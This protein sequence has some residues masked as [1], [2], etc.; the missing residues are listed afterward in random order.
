MSLL[1]NSDNTVRVTLKRLHVDA[2]GAQEPECLSFWNHYLTKFEFKDEHW[3]V[4]AEFRP[5]QGSRSRIDRGIR[6]LA[7]GDEIIVLCWIEAKGSDSNAKKKEAEQQAL[8]ACQV[9]LKSHRWQSFIYALTTAKTTA[10]AWTY[11]R[12][13]TEM[14]PLWDGGYVEANSSNATQL[15]KAFQRMKSFPPTPIARAAASHVTTDSSKAFPGPVAAQITSG[16]YGNPPDTSN[17]SQYTTQP[18]QISSDSYRS[19]T[20][21]S[22]PNPL[23]PQ[24]ANVQT[25]SAQITS[26]QSASHGKT[27]HTALPARPSHGNVATDSATH[28]APLFPRKPSLEG[29]TKVPIVK[30]ATKDGKEMLVYRVK[31]KLCEFKDY[32]RATKDGNDILYTT[33][34]DKLYVYVEDIK[35]ERPKK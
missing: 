21:Y 6:F 4:D 35:D 32:A 9:T 12:G 23:I 24:T 25:T 26:A 18:A 2:Q 30:M 10:Q 34:G 33:K 7:E 28:S 14:Q 16:G 13:E 15:R 22:R 27:Y 11:E 20:I 19:N 8:R 31:G 17:Y 5:E 3:I 1:L 29:Y